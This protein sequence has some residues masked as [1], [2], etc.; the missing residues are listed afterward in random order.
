MLLPKILFFPLAVGLQIFVS[1]RL[2]GRETIWW[3]VASV[4]L[5]QTS[6]LVLLIYILPNPALQFLATSITFFA[7]FR[8]VF[9]EHI[10]PDTVACY[11]TSLALGAAGELV[12][13]PLYGL[14]QGRFFVL[15]W[16]A[17]A[18]APYLRVGALVPALLLAVYFGVSDFLARK[19]KERPRSS[20]LNALSWIAVYGVIAAVRY[21]AFPAAHNNLSTESAFRYAFFG[22]CLLAMPVTL[23]FLHQHMT[24][25]Q[26]TDKSLQYHVKQHAIQKS[27]IKTLREERHDFINELTLISTYLQMGKIDEAMKCINYS[28]AK[29]ADRNNYATLPRDAWLTVLDLKQ[30]EAKQRNID[31]QVDVRAEAPSY[32]KEQRLLPKVIINLVDNAFNAVST[33]ANPQVT[34]SWSCNEAGERILAVS[35]NGPAISAIDGRMMFRGGVTTKKDHSGNH[36]WGLV[37]CRDIAKEL[38]GS[39]TYDSSPQK[40]SFM[41]TLAPLEAENHEQLMA[42]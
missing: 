25:M 34:L 1:L 32:F 4:A 16:I 11:L 21:L 22:G 37:I 29:L 5:L 39:L 27:A 3:K 2:L 36:G 42:N 41:L 18:F 38:G 40:T 30:N 19:T 26:K 13:Q 28:S 7:S 9:D 6:A 15:D 33:R 35:N 24:H 10:F 23:F 20:G 12:V 17:T 14:F 8:W 31:F